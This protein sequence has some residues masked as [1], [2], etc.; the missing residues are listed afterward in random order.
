MN[1]ELPEPLKPPEVL[2]HIRKMVEKNGGTF[3]I[4]DRPDPMDP[5][6]FPFPLLKPG[7]QP[8]NP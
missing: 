1:A 7:E 2:E 3:S 4:N 5:N 8:T 6:L